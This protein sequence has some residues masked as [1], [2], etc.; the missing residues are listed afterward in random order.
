M[1]ANDDATLIVQE[2]D[3]LVSDDPERALSLYRDA[4]ALL[5]KAGGKGNLIMADNIRRDKILPLAVKV[6]AK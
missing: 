4:Y 6:F 2:A 5:V 1:S 3:A